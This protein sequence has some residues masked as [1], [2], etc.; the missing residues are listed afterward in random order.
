MSRGVSIADS[1]RVVFGDALVD[2][3]AHGRPAIV[4]RFVPIML[5][6]TLS[7]LD[8]GAHLVALCPAETLLPALTVIVHR[9]LMVVCFFS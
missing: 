3:L 2:V 8:L 9:G 7:V 1:D 4:G 6:L 5:A